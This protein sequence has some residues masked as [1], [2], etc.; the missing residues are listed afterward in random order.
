MAKLV[1]EGGIKY[2]HMCQFDIVYSLMV[3]RVM[4]LSRD[5]KLQN[6]REANGKMSLYDCELTTEYDHPI[7][8]LYEGVGFCRFSIVNHLTC[9]KYDFESLVYC[10]VGQTL[11]STNTYM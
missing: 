4:V 8:T 11:R 2:C 9:K 3:Y 1:R 5:T 10:L 7:V 6:E